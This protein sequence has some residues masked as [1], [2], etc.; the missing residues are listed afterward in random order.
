MERPTYR[1][2]SRRDAIK[3]GLVTVKAG[4]SVAFLGLLAKEGDR[5]TGGSFLRPVKDSLQTVSSTAE[6]IGQDSPPYIET[7]AK[8]G[9][10]TVL[11]LALAPIARVYGAPIGSRMTEGDVA[12][13]TRA[14]FFQSFNGLAP[15]T[16][17]EFVRWFIS[18]SLPGDIADNWKTGVAQASLF[19][20]VSN[21]KYVP[22]PDNPQSEEPS[23]FMNGKL[24]LFQAFEQYYFWRVIREKGLL[25]AA[26]AHS[27]NLGIKLGAAK[28]ISRIS[29]NAAS[30]LVPMTMEAWASDSIKESVMSKFLRIIK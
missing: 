16:V 21:S 24:P 10:Y 25:H 18:F 6:Q 9:A 5:I 19:A 15:T 28:I 13:I 14:G 26:L 29:R 1:R 12:V 23:Y 27:V 4:A 17:Q 7:A 2:I 11:E 22:N 20:M 8:T 30:K 3:I